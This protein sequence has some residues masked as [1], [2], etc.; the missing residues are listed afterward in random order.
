M[1]GALPH[2]KPRSFISSMW[3]NI[4]RWYWR[5]PGPTPFHIPLSCASTNQCRP[6]S[7]SSSRGTRSFHF[8]GACD[9]QR[10]GGRYVRSMW[11]S[12]EMSLFVMTP[13]VFLALTPELRIPRVP[14]RITEEV[15]AQD[16][17]ADR[18]AREYREPRGL[19]HERAAGARQHQ[20]P[21]RGR[22]LGPDAEEGERRLDQDRVAEPDGGDD[23]DRRR[24]VRQDVAGDDARV[25]AAQGLRRLHVPVLLRREHRPAN[26]ARVARDDHDGDRDHRVGRVRLED[27]DDRQREHQFRD[28]LDRVHD[29]LAEEVEPTLAVATQEPDDHARRGA[30]ADGEESDPERDPAAVDDPA[31]D[32]AADVVRAERMS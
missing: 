15:E 31:Q 3:P 4:P 16:G 1:P 30:D 27:R 24:H 26:D 6:S 20:A 21:R 8:P 28:R 14:Q 29:A 23:E 13:P 7:S 12:P 9:D 17:Q 19:L 25:A 22:R 5:N 18:Q 2:S 11:L 10:S 32:V